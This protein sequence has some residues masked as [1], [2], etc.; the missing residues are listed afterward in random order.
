MPSFQQTRIV[1][2][3][4]RTSVKCS[5]TCMEGKLD[6]P[7]S[8]WLIGDLGVLPWREVMRER[9][10]TNCSD[11]FNYLTHQRRV[12]FPNMTVCLA[13]P[14]HTGTRENVVGLVGEMFALT[15]AVN[16]V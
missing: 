6:R 9:R 13:K 14:S 2:H 1:K 15:K 7:E 5:V 3:Q 8:V 10:C 16:A 4:V 12:V 11:G